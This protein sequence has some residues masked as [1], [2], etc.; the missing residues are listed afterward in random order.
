MLPPTDPLTS[1]ASLTYLEKF[2]RRHPRHLPFIDQGPEC[3]IVQVVDVA[4]GT[5][6]GT[7]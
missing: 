7:I 3:C 6:I 5:Q 2:L 1:F 4:F